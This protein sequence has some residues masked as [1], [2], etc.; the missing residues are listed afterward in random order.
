MKYELQQML[1][2][3]GKA[4]IVNTASISG[5]S[6]HPADPAYV[7]SKFGCVGL[8]KTAA[9]EYAKTGIR[10]NCVCPGPI[11]T[12][13]FDRVGSRRP[14]CCRCGSWHGSHGAGGRARG[15]GRGR[16]LALLG[17][18]FLCHGH[19]PFRRWRSGRPVR[20][21]GGTMLARIEKQKIIAARAAG[22]ESTLGWRSV[23]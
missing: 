13:L 9:L 1:K 19:G 18:R 21:T 11:H 8:T 16:R 20:G 22:R 14:R 23:L 17:C 2:Q 10:I 3:G 6:P 15:G 12:A 5:L 7:S 4:A